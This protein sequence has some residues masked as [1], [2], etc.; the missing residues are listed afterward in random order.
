MLAIVRD[1]TERKKAQSAAFA[2]ARERHNRK[3][4]IRA[5]Q[6]KSRFVA[7]ISHELRTPLAA[8]I[9]FNELLLSTGLTDEQKELV[10]LIDQSS[11]SLLTL[12][13]DVLDLSKIEAGRAEVR[14]SNFNVS[15]SVDTVANL[16]SG[17]AKEKKLKLNV[18]CQPE[19]P[20]MVVGDPDRLHQILVNL[21]NN[22]IK[23][24]ENGTVSLSAKLEMEDEGFVVVRFEVTDTGIG[25]S[26]EDM[27]DLFLPYSQVDSSDSRKH[28]GTGTG[29]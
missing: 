23:F 4:A 20:E 3:Q 24:T 1:I 27:T 22:G 6:L 16:M 7:N 2:L 8:I 5:S 11:H 13:N 18:F 14:A 15:A 28:G 21:V 25:I 19:I 12:V 9:G 10:E 17:P 26:E 29:A